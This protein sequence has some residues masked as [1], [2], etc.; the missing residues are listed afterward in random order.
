M[1][2]PLPFTAKDADSMKMN[3]VTPA[4]LEM[5]KG[6]RPTWSTTSI[7]NASGS[8]LQKPKAM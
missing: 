7:T 6:R 3:R 8:S 2:P 5:S 4:E 1:R